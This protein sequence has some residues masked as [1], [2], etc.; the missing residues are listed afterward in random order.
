MYMYNAKCE[1]GKTMQRS[2][3]KH[4]LHSSSEHSQCNVSV[5]RI[6]C[7][8]KVLGTK[9]LHWLCSLLECRV[10]LFEDRWMVLPPSHCAW[11][12]HNVATGF[13]SRELLFG[14]WINGMYMYMYIYALCF[15]AV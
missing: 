12:I 9:T 11:Y 10:C 4:T 2:S 5:P 6:C 7:L 14:H 1:G 15:Q 8:K 3:N 13:G